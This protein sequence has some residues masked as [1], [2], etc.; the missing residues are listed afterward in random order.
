MT[1]GSSRRGV[2]TGLVALSFGLSAA[3]SGFLLVMPAYTGFGGGHI[4]HQTLLEVN[5]PQAMVFLVF[6]VLVSLAPLLFP[7]RMARVTATALLCVFTLV[8]SFTIGLFYAPAAM[9]IL[10]ATCAELPQDLR[11]AT[12]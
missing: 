9:A 3:A 2:Q 10:M 5:G 7:S 1:G 11:S 12:R 8:S 4:E 6:P